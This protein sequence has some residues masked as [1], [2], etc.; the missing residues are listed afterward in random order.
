M[1]NGKGDAYRPVDKYNF[2]HSFERIFAA[3]TTNNFPRCPTCGVNLHA[4]CKQ[5]DGQSKWR[6]K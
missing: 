3:D 1:S 4:V 2:D 5:C 6:A